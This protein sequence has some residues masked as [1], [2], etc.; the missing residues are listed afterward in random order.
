M[1]TFK[2]FDKPRDFTISI[3]HV[4]MFRVYTF[5]EV[6]QEDID[7]W[8]KLIEPYYFAP[9]TEHY[10]DIIMNVLSPYFYS[11]ESIYNERV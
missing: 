7:K 6:T 1:R 4:P 11:I 2:F 10:R 5:N 9:K 8:T 3:Q